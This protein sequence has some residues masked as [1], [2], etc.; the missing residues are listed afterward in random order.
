MSSDACLSQPEPES[1]VSVVDL[2]H[3]QERVK[4]SKGVAAIQLEQTKVVEK[5][6][7]TIHTKDSEWTTREW[8]GC[9]RMDGDHVNF[10]CKIFV[11]EIFV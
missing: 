10:V 11:L 9:T 2:H 4:R 8:I 5:N 7:T 3:L 6:M 1:R